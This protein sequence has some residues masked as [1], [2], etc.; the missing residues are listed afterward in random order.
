M[1][2]MRE[3]LDSLFENAEVV[4]TG[5]LCEALYIRGHQ[6]NRQ[7]AIKARTDKAGYPLEHLGYNTWVRAAA[8]EPNRPV[9]QTNR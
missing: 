3:R 5:A 8:Q 7:R 4:T 6:N 2:T 1:K 9:G